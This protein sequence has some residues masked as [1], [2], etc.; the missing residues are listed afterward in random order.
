[1]IVRKL[2]VV[3]LWFIMWTKGSKHFLLCVVC[4]VLCTVDYYFEF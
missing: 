1:M 2:I 3:G 4:V